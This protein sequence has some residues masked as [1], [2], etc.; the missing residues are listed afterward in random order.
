MVLRF[1]NLPGTSDQERFVAAFQRRLGTDPGVVAC[2][3]HR[4]R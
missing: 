1:P 2:A 4:M 3:G